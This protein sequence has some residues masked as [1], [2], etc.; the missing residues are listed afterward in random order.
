[1]ARWRQRDALIPILLDGSTDLPGCLSYI[2]AKDV[3]ESDAI[4]VT[5][6]WESEKSH[7]DSLLLPSVLQAI[8]LGRPLIAGFGARTKTDPVGGLG[9]VP[10]VDC[11]HAAGMSCCTS[12]IQSEKA[13]FYG[14]E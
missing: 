5:E 12:V 11:E 14:S 1:M 9:L 7:R 3:V 2:V 6:V 4:W 10:G 13:K 8:A